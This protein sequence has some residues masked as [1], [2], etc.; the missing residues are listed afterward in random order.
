MNLHDTSQSGKVSG[1]PVRLPLLTRQLLWDLTVVPS[2]ESTGVP[3]SKD[4][5][6]QHHGKYVKGIRVLLVE[7]DWVGGGNTTGELSNTV[8]DAD[9]G[10]RSA[11]RLMSLSFEFV[12]YGDAGQGSIQG[13][14][15]RTPVSLVGVAVAFP[16]SKMELDHEHAEDDDEELLDAHAY[17]IDL[18]TLCGVLI[19]SNLSTGHF[20]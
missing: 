8:D 3:D 6:R 1:L 14:D 4:Q 13:V 2:Q 19:S 17:Q 18:Q 10:L 20:L 16:L 9:L 11:N 12:T 15:E 7:R 5:K